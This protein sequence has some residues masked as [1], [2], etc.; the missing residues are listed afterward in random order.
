MENQRE[1]IV[2]ITIIGQENIDGSLIGR[3]AIYCQGGNREIAIPW[4]DQ[5]FKK[6]AQVTLSA[7][8]FIVTTIANQARPEERLMIMSEPY[9]SVKELIILGGGH[10]AKP[11]T[12]IAKLLGFWVVVVDERPDFA[13]KKRF[14]EAD[15]VVLSSYDKLENILDFGPQSHVVI[16]TPGH[17]HDWI[18]LGQVLN[19]PLAYLGVIGSRQKVALTKEEMMKRGYEQSKV[20]AIYMP[21]GLDIGAETPEEIAISI[22]AELVKVRR[23]GNAASLTMGD[24][25]LMA[26]FPRTSN[27]T[28]L[29]LF[30]RVMSIAKHG[31]GAAVATIIKAE[32]STPCKIG[33]RMLIQ[34]DGSIYGTIGGGISE[35]MVCKKAVQIIHNGKPEIFLVNMNS[36]RDDR[37][38]MIC[39]GLIE[40]FIEP[41][42]MFAKG[43]A[44]LQL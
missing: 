7:G 3:K 19:Y 41:V 33:S 42:E 24:D 20:D 8:N 38:G 15:Q 9:V 39:G 1:P 4:V 43:F 40:V 28:Q 23:G 14:P 18:C 16:V 5:E 36:N 11:L 2:I 35:A 31:K 27:E 44:G 25:K 21:I 34:D 22:A 10:I 30:E 13:D 6:L 37:T 26:M 17:Q 32:G 12:K 29:D